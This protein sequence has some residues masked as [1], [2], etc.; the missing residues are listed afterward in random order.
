MP[1]SHDEDNTTQAP[2][3]ND[4]VALRGMSLKNTEWAIGVVCYTG[5]QTKIQMNTNKAVYK[6]SKVMMQTNTLIGMIFVLQLVLSILGAVLATQWMQANM[7]NPYLSF[8]MKGA[9]HVVTT[10]KGHKIAPAGSGVVLGMKET[11]SSFI[12]LQTMGTW[13]LIFTNF[14]PIS[15]LVTLELVKFWQGIFMESDLTMYDDD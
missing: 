12:F 13:L 15:L 7:D 3:S 9:S 10:A 2:L 11:D 4:G 8:V 6:A 1:S 14:V 5:H